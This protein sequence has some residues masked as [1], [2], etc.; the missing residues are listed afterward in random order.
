MSN[1][2]TG[3]FDADVEASN[4]E[5]HAVAAVLRSVA[6]T[7]SQAPDSYRYDID[8]TV[9]ERKTDAGSDAHD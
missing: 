8:L 3:W 5:P 1:R 4:G 6:D 9:T 7:V 2:D